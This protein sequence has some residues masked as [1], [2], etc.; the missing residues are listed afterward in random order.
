VIFSQLP[1][2]INTQNPNANLYIQQ[3][4]YGT[5]GLTVKASGCANILT[6][7]GIFNVESS[8]SNLYMTYNDCTRAFNIVGGSFFFGTSAMS[9]RSAADNS[10]ALNLFGNGVGATSDIFNIFTGYDSFNAIAYGKLF[11]INPNGTTPTASISGFTSNA[12]LI[13][14]NRGVGDLFTAS[15]GGIPRFTIKQNG[16]V[17]IGTTLPSQQLV[18]QGTG[19]Y[20][21]LKI[22]GQGTNAEGSIGFRSSNVA[23]GAS[24]DW[25][26]GV[27]I[28]GTPTGSFGLFNSGTGARTM[29]FTTGG[30]IGLGGSWTNLTPLAN[31][32]IRGTIN[33]FPIAS[34]SGSTLA[35]VSGFVVSNSGAGDIFTAS[36]GGKTVFTIGHDRVQIGTGS[37]LGAGGAATPQLLALDSKSTTG[38]PANGRQGDMYYNTVDEKF[39]CYQGTGW[40]DCIAASASE[41][42]QALRIA[43][44]SSPEANTNDHINFNVASAS[45]GTSIS[46]DTTS[47]YTESGGASRG[48]F[49]LAAGRTYI[50]RG[51]IP[52]AR[53]TASTG[54][55]NYSW[56]NV[57]S[58]TT[59]GNA[60][61]VYPANATGGQ[62]RTSYAEAV[63]TTN[64]STIVELRVTDQ[65]DLSIIGLASELLY[66]SAFIQVLS[67]AQE[68]S[69]AEYLQAEMQTL[70]SD[71]AD[72][73]ANDHIQF[74]T[75]NGFS[76]SSIR[77]DTSTTYTDG[78]GASIGRFTLAA[79]KTYVL[80]GTVP[81][82]DFSGPTGYIGYSWYNLTGSTRIGNVGF[83]FHADYTTDA[84]TDKGYG[85]GYAE[86]IITPTATTVVEMRITESTAAVS[87]GNEGTGRF[88][89]AFIE[90]LSDGT[91]VAQFTGATSST[92]GAIGY[93]PAP[94]AGQEGSLLL[95]NGTWTAAT[96]VKIGTTLT[97]PIASLSAR[98]SFAGLVVDNTLGDLFTASSSGQTR[99]VITQAGNVG[100][101]DIAGQNINTLVD[102]KGNQDRLL[103]M[104]E[105]ENRNTGSSVE[106]GLHLRAGTLDFDINL[107]GPNHSEGR[108]LELIT[109][110]NTPFIFN[111][112]TMSVDLL[113]LG[114]SGTMYSASVSARSTFAA[115]A[116]DNQTGDLFTASS[117]GVNRFVI[118]QNGQVGIGTA[119]TSAALTIRN[120]SDEAAFQDGLNVTDRTMSGFFYA[121]YYSI[122]TAVPYAS[123]GSYSPSRGDYQN[124]VFNDGNAGNIG[125]G[126]TSPTN[127]LN[128]ADSALT[129]NNGD[130]YALGIGNDD[131]GDLTFGSDETNTY[132]Q[133]WGGA[134][135]QLNNQGND[136]LI[137]PVAV[138]KSA[139]V[140]LPRRYVF[141]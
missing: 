58:G 45:A 5:S 53:F 90:V 21:N 59:I 7:P 134:T 112:S 95:G 73:A 9:V 48:R 120:N 70:E 57:T 92:D 93:V 35:G 126:T 55:M 25:V 77:L 13:V 91:Q 85:G 29:T 136:V 69:A 37:A 11:A 141:R 14:D 104:L 43:D 12:T 94:L 96:N 15:S 122:G 71:A 44:Q 34:V 102:V 124:V 16:N 28:N 19:N 98:T 50:L 52:I 64:T 24:G 32:D 68:V 135:L 40:R 99:F 46:L 51:T 62:N 75:V 72:I 42:L 121:N 81:E 125:I 116:V 83:L 17:G 18:I 97:Q 54:V 103:T 140:Q 26:L 61:G 41:Y 101:G 129:L 87:V 1:V 123:I 127:K 139:L 128:V 79:G 115:L 118:K 113:R 138:A 117:S 39:R 65:T 38:D 31:L 109:D 74:Q 111:N 30:A 6:D 88:P 8:D 133:S 63:I 106:T 89:S 4:N 2:G 132:I 137:Y 86:A 33:N 66:P 78:G 56:Y 82:A 108:G 22:I 49:T 114:Y 20:G 105:L 3:N 10:T 130:T 110:L 131:P 84:T 23:D 119:T 36:R 67:G 27:N 107:H 80:R 76:G 100:I 47:A 60:G